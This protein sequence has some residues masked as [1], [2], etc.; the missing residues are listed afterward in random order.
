MDE[1]MW[2]WKKRMDVDEQLYR[3]IKRMVNEKL[4]GSGLEGEDGCG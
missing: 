1:Y 2:I 3:W 4:F